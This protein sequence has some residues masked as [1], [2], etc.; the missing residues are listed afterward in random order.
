M[1]FVRGL[2]FEFEVGEAERHRV[3]FHWNQFWGISEIDVDGRK[4]IRKVRPFGFAITSRYRFTVGERERHEVLIEK[5]RPL[6]YAGFRPQVVRV[7]IDG[8]FVS[9]YTS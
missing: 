6:L 8:Q 4:V 5:K 2:D 1:S 3:H 7:F 9:E